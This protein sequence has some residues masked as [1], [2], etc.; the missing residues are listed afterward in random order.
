MNKY[1]YKRIQPQRLQFPTDLRFTSLSDGH[2]S[3][4]GKKV[5]V[6]PSQPIRPN[7]FPETD[8]TIYG[9]GKY[10]FDMTDASLYI[11]SFAN[12]HTRETDCMIL[13]KA[14]LGDLLTE[15]HRE[16]GKIKIK[17]FLTEK[18]QLIEFEGL[19]GEAFFIYAWMHRDFSQHLNNWRVFNK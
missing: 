5:K 4:N 18:C 17:L 6:L 12:A 1:S 11:F 3:C 13:T 9:L 2:L 15:H 8:A 19:S 10:S 7:D 16:S 14:E